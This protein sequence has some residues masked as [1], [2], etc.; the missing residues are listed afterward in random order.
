MEN[1]FLTEADDPIDIRRDN[2]FK[3]V[4]TKDTPE[5]TGALSKL[6]SAL[7]GRDVTIISILANEPPIENLRDR[8]IRFDIRC[9]AE[10]GELANVEMCLNP[11]VYE[12]IRLE[13]YTARLFGGQDIRGSDS[14]Y[15]DLKQTY[16]I[17]ILAN[18]KFIADNEYYHTF[19]YYDPIRGIPLDGRTQI[20]TLE[21]SK[22]DEIVEKPIQDMTV[23]ERWAVFFEY[24]TDRKR[25]DK[26]NSIAESEEGIAMAS[27]VLMNVSKDEAERARLESE[28]KYQMDLQSQLVTAKRERDKEILEMINQGSTLDELKQHLEKD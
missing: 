12:P 11:D 18:R 15:N 13:F 4:F 7:I 9:R 21:L 22:L 24:L 23:S 3:A 16:Q 27:H 19:L 25:R 10:N 28:Y 6:V 5:S 8:Q 17:A 26:I 2:V 20:I 14:S 1:I